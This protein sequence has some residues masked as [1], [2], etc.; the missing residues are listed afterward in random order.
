MGGD[1]SRA[2][3]GAGQLRS[4]IYLNLG[5]LSVRTKSFEGN[6]TF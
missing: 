5:T 1:G 6:S 3:K 2:R 4:K